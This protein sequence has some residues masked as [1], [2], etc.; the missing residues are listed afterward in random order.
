[1][2]GN[3]VD[4]GDTDMD[5]D[6][7]ADADADADADGEVDDENFSKDPSLEIPLLD[8]AN[9]QGIEKNFFKREEVEEDGEGGNVFMSTSLD[10]LVL[11]WD[12]RIAANGNN[13]NRVFKL[14]DFGKE[15]DRLGLGSSNHRA[16]GDTVENGKG[17]TRGRDQWC[18][19]V[20]SISPCLFLFVILSLP[21]K[22]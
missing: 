13:K 8:D 17:R 3:K 20:S 11:I 21:P 2:N 5:A 22:Y 19:S 12:K 15:L 1:V 16:G 18:T 14:E 4:D 7:E 6:G 9:V 10:G